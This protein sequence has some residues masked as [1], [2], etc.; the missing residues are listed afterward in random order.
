VH[1]EGYALVDV[2]DSEGERGPEDEEEEGHSFCCVLLI[3]SFNL[4]LSPCVE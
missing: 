2:G 4:V 3:A 1:Q